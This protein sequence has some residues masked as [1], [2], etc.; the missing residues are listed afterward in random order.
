VAL[1]VLPS[2]DAQALRA[3]IDA[4]LQTAALGRPSAEVVQELTRSTDDLRKL[5]RQNRQ[6][7]GDLAAAS[8]EDAERFL[9][10]LGGAGRLLRIEP[11]TAT[12]GAGGEG[13][14]GSYT[15]DHRP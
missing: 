3:R 8:Y 11:A 14:A 13:K 9:D 15:P 4:L 12:S 6:E 10:K 7:R 2:Q 1:R 5:L